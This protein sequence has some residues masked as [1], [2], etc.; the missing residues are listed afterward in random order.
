VYLTGSSYSLKAIH[1]IT[2]PKLIF[3]K[4]NQL[5]KHALHIVMLVLLSSFG[6]MAQGTLT[7]TVSDE[8][9][10][11]VVGATVRAVGAADGTTTDLNGGFKMNAP[12]SGKIVISYTGYAAQEVSVEGK[13][14][15]QVSLEPGSSNLQEV[16]VTALGIKREK[17]ALGYSAQNVSG[18]N[19]ALARETNIANSLSGRV[20]GLQITRAAGGVG[21]SSRITIR[22]NNSLGRNNQPL[23]VVDGVPIN[24]FQTQNGSEWGGYDRGNGIGD[25]NPDD[26]ESITVLKGPEATALYGVQGGNGAILINTKKGSTRRGLGVQVNSNLTFENPLALPEVQTQYAQGSGGLFD[27]KSNNAWGPQ[28]A[29]QQVEDWRNPGSTTPLTSYGNRFEDFLQTGQ[30][31]NNTISL[32]GGSEKTS[33]YASY[34]N[35][36]SQ[37]MLPSN[38]LDRNVAN[39][40]V[41]HS[42]NDRV[43]VDAKVTYINSRGYNRPRLSGDPENAYGSVL[44]LPGNVN[45]NDL[46]PGYDAL[47]R[48]MV[49]NPGG[50]NVIQNPYWTMNLNTTEDI[51]DRF[52]TMISSNVKVTDWLT[53]MLRHSMD[54]YADQ[55]EGRLAYGQRYNEPTG[56]FY[57]DRTNARTSNADY[58]LTA[59][60]RFGKIGAKLS[61]GGSRFD[62]KHSSIYGA[63][64]GNL[65][66]DFY[67]LGT[68]LNDRRSLSN[69]IIQKRINSAYALA[70][71]DYN[72]W[73]YLEGSYRSDWTSTLP[74]ANRRFD[75]TSFSLSAVLSETLDLPEFISFLKVRGALAQAGNDADPYELEAT[76]GIGSGAGAIV[77]GVPTT[78]YNP[79]LKNELIK[80]K[81]VGLEARFF[82]NRLGFELSLYQKN[83]LNQRIYLPV[84]PGSGFANKIINGGN[85]ENKGVELVLNTT[86]VKAG[87]FRWDLD[88]NYAANRNRLIELNDD[89]KRYLQYGPRAVF[90]VA[91]EGEL[92]GDIYGRGYVRN[93]NGEIVVDAAGLP[94]LT[95]S[96]DVFL[97]NVQAKWLG[98][99]SN[100]LT[101]K[102]WS[103]NFLVDARK[104]GVIYSE[105]E[106]QLHATGLS[107]NTL[108]NRDGG[109]VVDGVTESGERNTVEV[110]SQQYWERVAGP[111]NTAEP[112]VYDA[113][114]VMLREAILSYKFPNKMFSKSSVR[115][116]TIS[117][118]G[119]NLFIISKNADTPAYIL[120]SYISVG[121]DL[122]M[123]STSMPQARSFGFNVRLNF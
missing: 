10:Q 112:F 26:V 41:G 53:L 50:S 54:Y 8:N 4:F 76:Y 19:L 119:R 59:Y 73:L 14:S 115:D 61:A 68:G 45:V 31:W 107:N 83:A 94:K 63:N 56:N 38:T 82:G 77:S 42:L 86:P 113:S 100:T 106:S 22:G 9:G 3:M 60:K 5:S 30:T 58:L 62:F 34:T 18:E 67:N 27:I 121:N 57:Q 47:R 12:Q 43:S 74:V 92:F 114:N 17:K 40:R 90:I 65:V 109:L 48:V 70:S 102:A 105:T 55:N 23:I 95:D 71:L 33:F 1:F 15:V 72:N 120:N 49:W 85:V 28:I 111:N 97:G 2:K 118:V 36:S 69:S 37:G 87:S 7:G 123:E 11:P 80:S 110:S 98:G 78:I 93:D 116:L 89:T 52:L 13:S 35:T 66:V 44:F 122:G 64:N 46:A 79:D 104:G 101:Y 81:E 84:P 24:N 108:N 16:T 51:R 32:T 75:Y 96:K 99:L 88:L 117:F 20:A 6:L 103:L 91:D 29:G 39:L 21:S 25:V